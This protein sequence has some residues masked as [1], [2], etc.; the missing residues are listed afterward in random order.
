M[1][2]VKRVDTVRQYNDSVG[3]D[4]LHPLVSVVK[5][6]LCLIKYNPENW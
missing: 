5:W 4:T 3:V 6:S 1:E 2:E